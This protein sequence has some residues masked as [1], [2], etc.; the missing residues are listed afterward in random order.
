MKGCLRR[1]GCLV[2]IIAIAGVWCWYAR[3]E[4]LSGLGTAVSVGT[5][6]ALGLLI[7]VLKA[8]LSH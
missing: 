2:L 1:A 5:N 8:G 7:V 4:R 6:L 3:V